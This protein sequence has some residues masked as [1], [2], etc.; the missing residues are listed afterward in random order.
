MLS[1]AR[2]TQI[3]HQANLYMNSNTI[4]ITPS[5]RSLFDFTGKY[6]DIRETNKAIKEL[7]RSYPD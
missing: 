7:T 2:I 1:P 6:Q 3:L 4:V 5:R